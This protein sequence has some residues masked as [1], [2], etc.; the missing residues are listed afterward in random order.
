MNHS[1]QF[2]LEVSKM[3]KN[4]KKNDKWLKDNAWYFVY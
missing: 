4:Y 1:R 3:D 2:W